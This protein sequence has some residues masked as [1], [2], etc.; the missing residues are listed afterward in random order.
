MLWSKAIG[1]G[2]GKAGVKVSHL[3][4]YRTFY[5]DINRVFNIGAPDPTRVIVCVSAL[6]MSDTSGA[7]LNSLTFDSVDYLR[8]SGRDN[9]NSYSATVAFA[10][11]H[12]PTGT[13]L[14]VNTISNSVTSICVHMFKITGAAH[15]GLNAGSVFTGIPANATSVSHYLNWS[16]LYPE[17]VIFSGISSYM[18]GSYSVESAVGSDGNMAVV[19]PGNSYL[20]SAAYTPEPTLSKPFNVQWNAALNKNFSSLSNI[21]GSF[22]VGY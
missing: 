13:S 1:A 9:T 6:N 5:T 8:A 21:I 15:K 3:G 22:A 20:L 4:T 12:V 17:A 19:E 10:S 7:I 2:G 16:S 14:R 18:G 11:A